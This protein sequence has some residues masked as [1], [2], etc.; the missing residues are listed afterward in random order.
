MDFFDVGSC[1]D[2]QAISTRTDQAVALRR[3]RLRHPVVRSSIPSNSL[4]CALRPGRRMR[5]AAG[6]RPDVAIDITAIDET[7]TRVRPEQIIALIERHGGFGMV[8]LVGVQSNQFPRAL[9]IAR[10]LR[11]AGIP[12]V[13]GGF[14][15]S[16]CLAMLPEM[17]ADLQEALDMG[18]SLF[19]GEAGRAGSTRCCAM[20]PPARSSRSTIT[21][22]I[23]RRSK[24]RRRRTCRRD[25]LRRT[26]E[27][28][29]S[30]DAGRGCPFQCSFCTI[31][32]VQGRKSR[33]RSPDDVEQ[34]DPRS[35][36]RRASA[37]SSSPTTIS[38]ATR[39]GKRS[40]TAS[41][42]CASA[43]DGRPAASSRSTRC[44]TRSR[45]SSKRRA[46]A[47]VQARLHRAREH[48]SGQ[49]D[50]RQEAAE[51][52]HRIPQDAAGLE[53]GRR[54]H[55]CG[56]HPRLPGRHAGVDPARTSRSSRGSCRSTSSSSSA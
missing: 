10:P 35:T 34:L 18:S 27:H 11:A 20:P 17:Q 55:L 13:I 42:C 52:D 50:G 45:T 53:E 1:G 40:S 31:I 21:W 39:I 12:V 14:H 43:K 36:R 33:R 41:S 32:N 49:P 8:G 29:A 44:A 38:R 19:A 16:G 6:A 37:A 4:A 54:H 15:V 28:H 9:D 3:R 48:Q 7:N 26:L 23:C 22:T 46:R 5:G 24:A 25:V 30:F 2:T 51:Q 56:L 47:G